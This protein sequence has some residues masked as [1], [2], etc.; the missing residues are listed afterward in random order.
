MSVYSY[1]VRWTSAGRCQSKPFEWKWRF[2]H[3]GASVT[4]KDAAGYLWQR[5]EPDGRAL[6]EQQG[7]S[8]LMSPPVGDNGD[9]PAITILRRHVR[10]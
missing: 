9:G 5:L 8:G 7:L 2:L 6:V 4:E 3:S 1:D 10:H